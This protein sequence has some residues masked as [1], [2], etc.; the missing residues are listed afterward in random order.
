M[1]LKIV[2]KKE[3]SIVLFLSIYVSF[4]FISIKSQESDCPR[5]NPILISNEC[6]LQY[7]SEEQFASKQCIIKNEIIKTQWLNNIIILGDENYRYLNFG[8]YSNGDMVIQT[9]TY[10]ATNTRKFYGIK[11]NGRPFFT[12]D[13]KETPYYTKVIS[14]DTVGAFEAQSLIVK[15]SANGEEYFF[16]ISKH[17]CNAE[18]FDLKNG[19]VYRTASAN[20]TNTN[21]VNSLK[22]SVI[23]IT[24]TIPGEYHYLLAFIGKKNINNFFFLFDFIFL[25]KYKFTS[26]DSEFYRQIKS[27]DIENPFGRTI[28]CF[29]TVNK[30]IICFYMSTTY[31]YSSFNLNIRKYSNELTDDVTHSFPVYLKNGMDDSNL[32]YKCTHLKGEVGVFAYYNLI[33]NSYYQPYLLF[34]EFNNNNFQNYLSSQESISIE[35]YNLQYSILLNDLIKIN[36][37]KIC[38]SSISNEKETI[39]IIILNLSGEKKIRIRYYSIPSFTLY[40]YKILLDISTH[41]YKNFISFSSSF[42]KNENCTDDENPH[43]SALMIFSYP[44][45]T[46]Y[47]LDLEQ[48]LFNKT[49]SIND[50]AIDLKDY[51]R[52][53][54]NIFGYI[55]N[56]IL[57]ENL[58]EC[59]NIIFYSS[60]NSTE[61]IIAGKIL[62]KNETIKFSLIEGESGFG[63]IN[64]IIEYVYKATEPDINIYETYPNRIEGDDDNTSFSKN[65]Y[66]GRLT[67]YKII[68]NKQLST[69]CSNS[70]CILCSK[71]PNNHCITCKHN[72]TLINNNGLYYKNC[73]H[74][75]EVTEKITEIDSITELMT[76]KMTDSETDTDSVT[77]EITEKMTDK[78]TEKKTDSIIETLTD[79]ITDGLTEKMS[80]KMVDSMTETITD[81]MT[82]RITEILTDKIL[83]DDY[84]CEEQEIINNKCIDKEIGQ[85]QIKTIFDYLGSTYINRNITN[86]NVIIETKNVLF[87]ITSHETQKNNVNPNISDIDLGDCEDKLKSVY[88]LNKSDQ[89]I[90]LKTDIKSKDLVHT[91]VQ[92]QVYHPYD[93]KPLNL[94]V[95]DTQTISINAPINLEQSVSD[96]Y[97]HLKEQGYNL[98]NANDEFYT[99]ICSTYTSQS[100]TDMI[101]EDRKQEIFLDKGNISLCQDNCEFVSY[102][103]L[104][105]KAKCECSPQIG[106]TD[107][108]SIYSDNKFNF[109]IIA[110]SFF[111]TLNNSHFRALKCYKLAFDFQDFFTNIG[112]ILMTII[113]LLHFIGLNVFIC[114]EYNKINKYLIRIWHFK[115]CLNL[116]ENSQNKGKGNGDKKNEKIIEKSKN[117]NKN[118]KI[119]KKMNL[120]N[121]KKIKKENK[122]K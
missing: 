36:R 40:H 1:T 119:G 92:Y 99:D 83:L 104:I 95:C 31:D 109:S 97:D 107:I 75:D 111:T 89:L 53:E 67:Y 20:F 49:S 110:D 30:I 2:Y 39:H 41:T 47:T 87:Q 108:S 29:E 63:I 65:E 13:S 82:D 9:T 117:N 25:Q 98:F 64:C 19:N 101:L 14:E 56:G 85:N 48:I 34:I 79:K 84:K 11:N 94:S 72:Y 121:K 60:Q 77:N 96:L 57:I 66:F 122:K 118:Q 33:D 45:S 42:C 3:S 68:L 58:N 115:N 93:L 120:D 6:K 59:Q 24:S 91:Y 90:I 76:E 80:D 86:Q 35:I 43:S 28:S 62:N 112:R 106:K 74:L 69:N 55:F 16:C 27:I 103:S 8:S 26:S 105:K 23:P 73:I 5:D 22:S 70:D 102:N 78:M 32:F 116:K 52:I 100:G 37:N 44:N 21:E 61:E 12:K 81:K 88:Q 114:Y 7:C 71:T 54:N 46:D 4:N 38:F 113:I 50:L 51:I 18:M 15:D 10:P 17:E